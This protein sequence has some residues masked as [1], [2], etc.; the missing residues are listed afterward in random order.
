MAH[1]KDAVVWWNEKGRF[2]GAKAP[3]VRAFMFDS[4]FMLD[5]NNYYLELYSINRSQGAHL[6]TYLPP[7]TT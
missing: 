6:G 2:S 3:E 5:S 1:I 7:A 4:A